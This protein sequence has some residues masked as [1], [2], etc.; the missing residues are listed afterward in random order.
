MLQIDSLDRS[1]LE[2]IVRES[3]IVEQDSYG[4]KVLLLKDG[5]YLK[6]FRRKRYFNSEL[7]SPAAVRFARNARRL[8]KLGIPTLKVDSLHRISGEPHTVAIYRPLPGDTLRSFLTSDTAT[9]E[10]MYRVGV[11]LARLHRQGV[12]FRSVHPGNI[13]IDGMTIGLIDF[14]D[15]KIRPW[16][17][18]RWSRRRNWK[19]LFGRPEDK[20]FWKPELVDT[21]LRGYYDAADLPSREVGR[22]E[23]KISSLTSFED[24]WPS[25]EG[26]RPRR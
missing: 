2:A 7:L 8:E 25:A 16:S 23:M 9:E 4:V 22:I 20:T 14:L 5:R 3:S 21:L 13:I 19:H 15:M 12:Y 11:F 6:Y 26:P 18:L 1:R 24:S 17:M 10:L